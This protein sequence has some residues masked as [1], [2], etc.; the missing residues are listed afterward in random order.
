MPGRTQTQVLWFQVVL[1]CTQ[2][3][4]TSRTSTSQPFGGSSMK[5][6]LWSSSESE[7]T[8]WPKNLRRLAVIVWVTEGWA[9]RVRSDRSVS[10]LLIPFKNVIKQ[11]CDSEKNE[12]LILMDSFGKTITCRWNNNRVD[13][14]RIKWSMTG[15]RWQHR[16]QFFWRLVLPLGIHR[17]YSEM[18][19]T[20]SLFSSL[21][22]GITV[23]KWLATI[24]R[25]WCT[26]KH[27]FS[28]PITFCA[29]YAIYTCN[30]ILYTLAVDKLVLNCYIW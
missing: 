25:F 7:R 27:L 2:P 20:L 10:V 17:S 26:R 24:F 22:A 14:Q 1:Y 28:L 6:R 23:L 5:A 30:M 8:M 11:Q 13:F 15:L 3:R 16:W 18:M 12:T 19:L 29:T 9:D 4:L 21:T